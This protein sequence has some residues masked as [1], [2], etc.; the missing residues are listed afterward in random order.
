MPIT[1]NQID[2]SNGTFA[3]LTGLRYCSSINE[4][5][6]SFV[7]FG[8]SLP[9]GS[10]WLDAWAAFWH[11]DTP[12]VPNSPDLSFL[13]LAAQSRA[14][15]AAAMI[16]GDSQ[17]GRSFDDLFESGDGTDVVVGIM[18]LYYS[19]SALRKRAGESD[20]ARFIDVPGWTDVLRC[21]QPSQPHLAVWG[22][23]PAKA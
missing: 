15:L 19:N 23:L 8:Q 12:F 1:E 6:N 3:T 14:R 2:V 21:F 13:P 7:T 5:R 16:M 4:L 22:A 11:G 9:S 10:T 17:F 20:R 18:I